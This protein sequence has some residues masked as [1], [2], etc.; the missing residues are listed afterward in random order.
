MYA[1]LR[2]PNETLTKINSS[3]L[4]IPLG[5]IHI[6]D[7]V[8]STQEIHHMQICMLQGLVHINDMVIIKYVV[9]ACK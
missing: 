6:N 2:V 3:Y 9:S 8:V 1:K 7:L 5:L 4:L